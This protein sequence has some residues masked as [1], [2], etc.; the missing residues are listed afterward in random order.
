MSVISDAFNYSA[1]DHAAYEEIGY[2][3]FDPF[4]SAAGLDT[5]RRELD[6][7]LAKLQPGRSADEIFSAHQQ[8][9]WLW[10]LATEPRLLDMIERQIGRDIVLWSSHLVCKAP[11]SGLAIPWYQDA[12]YWNVSGTL[13]S[14]VWIA[15]D[16]IDADNGGMRILPRWHTK[17]QLPIETEEG[18]LFS[19]QIAAS[20]LPLDLPEQTV[21]Y[22]MPAGGLAIHHTMIPHTSE[23]NASDRWRRVITFRYVAADGTFGAKQYPD[24]RTGESFD[25]AFYLVRGKDL[26]GKGLKSS[27]F[28]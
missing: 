17:G 10:E 19:Q 5:C 14:G 3:F 1:D 26:A 11:H 24:Y 15:L 6:A 25:R 2:R 13:A 4:L 23:P 7:M 18:Q 27:P 9:R 21:Q 22:R 8:E 28:D 16:D 12:P 20:A